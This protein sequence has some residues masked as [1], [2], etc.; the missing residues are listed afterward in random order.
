MFVLAVQYIYTLKV[1]RNATP[2]DT[3]RGN[4]VCFVG[5]IFPF[6]NTFRM[7][8]FWMIRLFVETN[9]MNI[10]PTTLYSTV[11]ITK[12]TYLYWKTFKGNFVGGWIIKRI[13][14]RLTISTI[15]IFQCCTRFMRLH[16]KH[17]SFIGNQIHINIIRKYSVD[18][19]SFEQLHRSIEK[20]TYHPPSIVS[21]NI[22]NDSAK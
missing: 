10:P 5:R 16:I 4:I 11:N 1:V 20:S 22:T 19:K 17:Y 21:V 8:R 15:N 13:W 14:M 3:K 18:I 9:I 7:S 12:S 2:L 6:S